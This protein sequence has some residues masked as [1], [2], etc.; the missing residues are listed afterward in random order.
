MRV[1]PE[2]GDGLPDGTLCGCE[3]GDSI[4]D[5]VD[6]RDDLEDYNTGEREDYEGEEEADTEE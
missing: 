2:C 6:A 5:W 4:M 1:C 3:I